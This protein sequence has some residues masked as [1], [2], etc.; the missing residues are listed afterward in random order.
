M[1]QPKVSYVVASYNHEEFVG[2]LLRSILAQTFTD[3]ELV[4]VD[5]GSSDRT[6]QIAREIASTDPRVRVYGQENVGVVKARNRGVMQSH[7][8]YVSVVDS[9]D[10]LPSERTRWQVEALDAAPSASLVY[11]DAWII[12]RSGNQIR[13]RFQVYPPVPGDF[14][15]ELFANY[16]FVPAVTVMFRRSA[17]DES[18]PFWGP[19]PSTDYLKWIELGLFGEAVCLSGKQLGCWRLHGNNVSAGSARERIRQYED[20]RKALQCLVQQYPE[21]GRRIGEHRLRWRYGRCH[22]MG[23]FYAGLEH[24]WT[25][26]R[27]H[28]RAAYHF[29][30]SFLNA[31]AWFSTFPGVNLIS[32]PFYG[33]TRRVRKL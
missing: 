13:R 18:G 3:L 32:S 20:L 17:F 8:E 24:S 9:D 30:P 16:C 11:G 31:S 15:V 2:D 29:N 4:V 26:A 12:D 7:G 14:S 21:L 22:F 27:T 6:A 33:L 25:L 5:D 10:L 23:A 19:G 28:F 1:S